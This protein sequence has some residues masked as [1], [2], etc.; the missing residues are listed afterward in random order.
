M[1]D[2]I[3]V[4]SGIVLIAVLIISYYPSV[5]YNITADKELRKVKIGS[6]E[7]QLEVCKSEGKYKDIRIESLEKELEWQK[8]KNGMI[9]SDLLKMKNEEV[10]NGI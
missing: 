10:A 3:F 8:A 7:N 9:I 5:L 6:I 1:S 2:I 4:V